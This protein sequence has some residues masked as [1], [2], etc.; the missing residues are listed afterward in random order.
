[1]FGI[2]SQATAPALATETSALAS[3]GLF[4]ETDAGDYQRVQ[5]V[6]ARRATG[7]LTRPTTVSN[8]LISAT[9][10]EPAERLLRRP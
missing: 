4:A 6:R 7:F 9:F 5:R 8:L 10:M 1:M 2:Q 3:A